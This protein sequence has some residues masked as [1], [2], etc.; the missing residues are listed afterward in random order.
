MIH[1]INIKQ[2]DKSMEDGY[3]YIGRSDKMN[4]PLG[5]PYTHKGK[6]T[7]LAKL[8]FPTVEQAIEAY[9]MYFDAMYGKDEEFTKA[10][11][12]IYEY[13]KTGK[14]VYLGCFC[15]PKPCHA[16]VIAKKLQQKLIKEKMVEIKHGAKKKGQ[17]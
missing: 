2:E 16:D 4:S 3:F 10:F 17:H 5:N 14:D 7:S 12:E 1:V 15:K 6:R 13:Y 9:E 11:D 8:S